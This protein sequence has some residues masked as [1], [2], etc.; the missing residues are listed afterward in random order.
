MQIEASMLGKILSALEHKHRVALY[1]FQKNAGKI[2]PYPGSASDGIFLATKAKGIYKPS[3]M[4]YALS[5]R[6]TLGSPYPDLEPIYR[7]DG[8]WYYMYFQEGEDLNYPESLFTNAGLMACYADRIPVGVMIQVSGKPK[9]SYKILGLALVVGWEDG[10]FFLEGFSLDGSARIN[11]S[12]QLYSQQNIPEFTDARKSIIAR[13]IQRQGQA[14]FRR[15]LLDSYSSICVVSGCNFEP[16][17]QAAHI[18]P[19]LGPQTNSPDNG[20][21]LRADIDNL[22]DL[23]LIAVAPETFE[24]II[25]PRLSSTEYSILS[26]RRLKL[27]ATPKLIPNQQA[28]ANHKN[29][30]GL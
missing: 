8:T 2:T 28:L 4:K 17:L 14:K 6:Q 11:S 27:P 23:G 26:G 19:Y 20:L 21:L 3:W 24:V 7:P 22:F 9:V 5:I 15:V 10:Y 29:W 30:A 1:W 18:M 12:P 25:S 13:V 16:V